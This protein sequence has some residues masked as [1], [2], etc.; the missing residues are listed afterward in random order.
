VNVSTITKTYPSSGNG[1]TKSMIRHSIG[2]YVEGVRH[3]KKTLIY[4]A[5][6][7][8][9]YSIKHV[10]TPKIVK[11]GYKRIGQFPVS[12]KTTI[13]RCTR[14]VSARDMDIM[15]RAL[16]DM[17]EIFRTTG[18]VNEAQMDAAGIFCVNG[19]SSN[20]LRKSLMCFDKGLLLIDDGFQIWRKKYTSVQFEYIAKKYLRCRYFQTITVVKI[21]VKARRCLLTSLFMRSTIAF[22]SFE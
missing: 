12:F 10:L 16:P 15:E 1:P 13:G 9:V 14:Q 6:Q 20:I 8:V 18:K 19:E 4:N 5:L 7:Q 11:T 2:V 3:R 17:V 22:S 21:K